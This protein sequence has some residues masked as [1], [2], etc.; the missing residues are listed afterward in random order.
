MFERLA[1]D[2][3]TQLDFSPP[4]LRVLGN[5][6]VETYPTLDALEH[7]DNLD[8]FW[9]LSTYAFEVFRRGLA[10]EAR[11]PL[12]D[13]QSQYFGMPVLYRGT[14]PDVCPFDLVTF[15]VIRRDPNIL[16]W[17]YGNQ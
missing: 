9:G 2:V 14:G 4:S 17:V 15:A 5:Y 3:A 11:L 1:E 6:L 13:P 12:Y 16:H 10:L 8:L 7:D